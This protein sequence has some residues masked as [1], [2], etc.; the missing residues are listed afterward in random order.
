MTIA[1]VTVEDLAEL[2]PLVSDYCGFYGVQPRREALEALSRALIADPE[3]AG[4]QLIAR[5]GRR[6]PVG[7]A[8]VFWSWSTLSAHRVGIMN[9]LFV[10]P[11]ARGAGVGAALIDASRGLCREHGARAL[12]WQTAPDNDRAQALYE[13][14]GARRE[15]WIDYS[16]DV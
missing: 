15:E 10:V 12:E 13:R 7:F 14:V 5:G 6:S 11:E 4:A 3:Q 1:T 8:T 16:L 9:D 2:L